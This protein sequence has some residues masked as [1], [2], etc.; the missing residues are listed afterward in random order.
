[1]ALVSKL[2]AQRID[3]PHEEGQ[4]ITIKPVS[5]LVM[6]DARDAR[7]KRAI[8]PF[9]EL[10]A[11]SIAALQRPSKTNGTSPQVA[12]DDATEE[13]DRETLLRASVVEWSYDA[14]VTP[15]NIDDLD[16]VTAGFIYRHAV[17]LNTRSKPEGEA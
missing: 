8:R 10:P 13:Y 7:V 3:L 17:S 4:W 2:T 1:M 12:D 14:P 9:T 15:A 16:D 5:W 11:E 6:R